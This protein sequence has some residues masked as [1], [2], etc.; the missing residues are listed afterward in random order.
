[1]KFGVHLPT[2][3]PACTDVDIQVAINETAILAESLKF[4]AIWVN[5][6]V[7]DNALH[8]VYHAPIAPLITL[9]SLTHL[10]PNINLGLAVMVLS[11]RNPFFVAKQVAALD[12][13][14]NERFT[15]GI[16]T[17]WREDEFELLG[18]DYKNRGA[19]ADEV[20]EVLRELWRESN[21]SF[22]GQYHQ[23]S[24]LHMRPKPRSGGP[25]IWV[26]GS[27]K[28]AIRRVAKIGADGWIPF[29]L[30]VDELQSSVMTL[31][32]LM[33]SKPMPEIA[34][35]TGVRVYS[36][37]QDPPSSLPP[38][39]FEA[40]IAGYPDQI[41]Q[42]LKAYQTVGLEHLLCIFYADKLADQLEQMRLFA[43]QIMPHF[44]ERGA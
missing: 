29:G 34:L 18:A 1:M 44:S 32:E 6:A 22:D 7:T 40:T 11:Q 24:D 36:E 20:V 28:Q 41:I 19:V 12:L 42:Q 38:Y 25:R 37:G 43:E 21:A 31:R 9:A 39:H 4:D 30:S 23:F 13:L 27:F 26:G 35:E 14:S 2:G 33:H 8:G 3:Y 16:G 17:G 10:V 5:D 15:L